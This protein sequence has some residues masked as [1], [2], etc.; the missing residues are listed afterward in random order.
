[1]FDPEFDHTYGIAADGGAPFNACHL[2][3]HYLP[4]AEYDDSA[5]MFIDGVPYRESEWD[6]LTG[7]TSQYGYRGAVMHASEQWSQGML[8]ELAAYADDGNPATQTVFAVVEV[9]APLC[10][11]CAD[12]GECADDCRN[13]PPA[14]WAV[15]YRMVQA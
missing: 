3:G 12:D 13:A 8:T 11:E 2:A 4:T 10:D 9:L 6:A 5:D 14:G 7:W 1:M 15:I